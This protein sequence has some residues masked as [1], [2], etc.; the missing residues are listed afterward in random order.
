MLYGVK[1]YVLLLLGCFSDITD[2]V[3]RSD[4]TVWLSSAD[5]N[6]S[7]SSINVIKWKSTNFVINGECPV[8]EHHR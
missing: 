2:Q 1:W 5:Q 8:H 7:I 4:Q 6:R 3:Q